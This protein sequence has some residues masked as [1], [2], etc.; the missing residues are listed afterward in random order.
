MK[1]GCD[2]SD[3][4]AVWNDLP[5]HYRIQFFLR[6]MEIVFRR[7]PALWIWAAV[8]VSLTYL[9]ITYPLSALAVVAGVAC[10]MLFGEALIPPA[11]ADD[12]RMR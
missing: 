2:L 4:V 3:F 11:I 9:A 5:W 6:V 8:S 1:N 12:K 7:S 10:T